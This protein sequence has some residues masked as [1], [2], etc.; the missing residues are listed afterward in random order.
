MCTLLKKG[1]FPIKEDSMSGGLI[2]L[3]GAIFSLQMLIGVAPAEAK[4]H[5]TLQ[6]VAK[7]PGRAA[8]CAGG[9]TKVV[10]KIVSGTI[11]HAKE[12]Y[13]IASLV[14][15]NDEK[16][17]EK[18]MYDFLNW[19]LGS[20]SAVCG[21]YIT[22]GQKHFN[23]GYGDEAAASLLG[24]ELPGGGRTEFK[25]PKRIS[26]QLKAQIKS[27]AD[28]VAGSVA[29]KAPASPAPASRSVEGKLTAQAMEKVSAACQAQVAKLRKELENYPIFPELQ[30]EAIKRIAEASIAGTKAVDRIGFDIHKDMLK[31][32]DVET[33]TVEALTAARR[34][35]RGAR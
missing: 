4:F 1:S 31:R 21:Q 9:D 17:S 12:K 33:R 8:E 32:W 16:R 23:R 14:D 35:E 5:K 29:G 11:N 25:L 20:P 6:E 18:E 15:A 30:D 10:R 13:K 28:Q 27:C 24:M 3:V 7:D 19:K 22:G 2:L 34:A 26:D